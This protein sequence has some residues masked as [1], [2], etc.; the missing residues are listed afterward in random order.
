MNFPRILRRYSEGGA[1]YFGALDS[2]SN[3]SPK[4]P[5]RYTKLQI[6]IRC[7]F[8]PFAHVI[9]SV[10]TGAGT[11]VDGHH[12][13]LIMYPIVDMSQ[14]IRDGAILPDELPDAAGAS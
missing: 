12:S 14:M 4:I 1:D 10:R 13:G 2:L 9:S 8:S 3:I 7:L 11:S 5:S 6:L